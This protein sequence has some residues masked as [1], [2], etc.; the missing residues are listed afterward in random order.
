MKNLIFLFAV[1]FIVFEQIISQYVGEIIYEYNSKLPMEESLVGETKLFF[2]KDSSF[3]QY[4]GSVKKSEPKIL[5]TKKI[6]SSS[7]SEGFPIFINKPANFFKQ[8]ISVFMGERATISSNLVPIKWE[9]LNEI[10]IDSSGLVLNKATCSYGGRKYIAWYAKSLP[11]SFGPFKLHGLPGLIIEAYTLD[12]TAIFRYKTLTIYGTNSKQSSPSFGL[13]KYNYTYDEYCKALDDF[14]QRLILK[15]G[16]P[17][18]GFEVVRPK[19]DM[20]LEIGF[21]R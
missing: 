15:S 16:G 14:E 7:D 5:G 4:L 20:Q 12:G 8:K 18:S 3:F 13:T 2:S 9:E 21:K 17:D 19:P 6:V 1:Q 10:K 11:Y